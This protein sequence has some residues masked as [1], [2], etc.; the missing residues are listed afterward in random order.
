MEK[1]LNSL[2]N[3]HWSPHYPT[4]YTLPDGSGL[5]KIAMNNPAAFN[6][7]WAKYG[8]LETIDDHRNAV[9]FFAITSSRLDGLGYDHKLVNYAT[10]RTQVEFREFYIQARLT[11]PKHV[12]DVL[13]SAMHAK[14]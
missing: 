2:I 6:L 7:T 12:S 3:W 9:G 13:D 11:L 1:L 5:G 4:T 8:K 10:M 14:V